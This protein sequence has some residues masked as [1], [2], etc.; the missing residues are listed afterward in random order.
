VIYEADHSHETFVSLTEWEL[1][2]ACNVGRWMYE[3]SHGDGR[4]DAHGFA[5][6]GAS[7]LEQQML[8]AIAERVVAKALGIYWPG[9]IDQGAEPDLPHDIEVRLMGR[10]H[11]GL[12]LRDKDP[13]GRRYVAVVIEPTTKRGP[14]RIPGWTPGT[15]E[16]DPEWGMAPNGRPPMIAVPQSALYPLHELAEIITLERHKAELAQLEGATHDG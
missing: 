2:G 14:Y 10:D 1:R 3:K 8:G 5:D 11:Y 4:S 6:D 15:I 16:I 9:A 7:G 12:R 13:T